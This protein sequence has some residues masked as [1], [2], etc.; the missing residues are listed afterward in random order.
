MLHRVMGQPG[1]VHVHR[2]LGPAGPVHRISINGTHRTHAFRILDLPLVAAEATV[3][4]LPVTVTELDM[5]GPQFDGPAEPLWRGMIRRGLLHGRIVAQ[6]WR[7]I[8]EPSTPTPPGFC[9]PRN[10][11]S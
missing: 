10:R 4:P 9:F 11:P 6:E 8:L 3:H 7:S 2:L 1:H 5:W